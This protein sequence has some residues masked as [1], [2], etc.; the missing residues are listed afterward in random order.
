MYCVKY[1]GLIALIA[2]VSTAAMGAVQSNNS[3]QLQSYVAAAQQAA[4]RRDFSAAADSYR[5][6]VRVSPNNAE[7]WADLGLMYHETGNLGEAIK[8]FTEA[9]RL[10]ASLYVPQLFLGID[11][12]ELKHS[13]AAIPF[14][15]KAEKLNPRDPQA[16]IMLGRAF[17][18]AGNGNSS[19]DAFWRAVVLAP[20]NGDVWLGMGASYLL[21]VG[22]DARVMTS[23]GT[24][25][26]SNYTKLRAGELFAEQG[27]LVQAADAYKAESSVASPLPCSHAGYGIVLLRQ[28]E[29]PKAKAEFDR[30][31]SSNSG[32][33]LTR[34]GL[35][36][37]QLDQGDAAT[38]LN[39]LIAIWNADR[40]FLGDS[41]PLL[42]GQIATKNRQKLF[43]L[44]IE[45]QAQNK[46]PAEF[47]D[48]IQRELKSNSPAIASL[49]DSGID[50][51]ETG[52]KASTP[53]SANPEKL[54][55]SGKFSMCSQSLRAHLSALPEKSLSLLAT[56][57]FYA[58]DDRTA[59][60]AAR[61][62][63]ANPATRQAGLYWES[64]ADEKLAV[65]AL[66]RAGE[67]DA[68]SPRMHVLL[69]DVYRQKR[70]WEEAETEYRK[71]IALEPESRDGRLGLA[72]SLFQD[73]NS[74]EAFTDDRDLLQKN[75]EDPEAN[76]LAA[77]IL[78]QRHQFA[79]AET[80]LTNCSGIEPE[81]M[82]RIHALRGEVYA[83]TGRIPQ[84]LSEFKLVTSGDEDGSIHY[85]M[86]RLYLQTGNKEAAAEAF[87]ASKQLRA[88]W[89]ASASVAIQQS[90]TD[91]SRR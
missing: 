47:V 83:N 68:D 34:L 80:Y 73:G 17:A 75:P 12:L 85:Q 27:K 25:R 59:A 13:E 91:I 24:D 71:A 48:L 44:A 55:Y 61:R 84:A 58:G 7:L 42:G 8:S 78:V 23:T 20:G 52:N 87:Q 39:G 56:C 60:L 77:E 38:A 82:P 69:G 76:M 63:A 37:W 49:S 3:Q 14:L 45:W 89:D 72:I 90:S 86:A 35:A 4:A 2:A 29:M 9:V 70:K 53:V 51:S 43:D 62:L 26:D 18:I 10:N 66:T 30:E 32:C 31:A 50:L 74:E 57:A 15:Q 46:I 36:A 21:Q 54:Y 67:T 41:L 6:A 1:V 5:N 19:I 16:P 22:S 88:Q 65:A 64:R 33:P 28:G 81:F 79:D 11:E 40:G